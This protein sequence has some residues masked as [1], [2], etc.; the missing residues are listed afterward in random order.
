MRSVRIPFGDQ[1]VEKGNADVNC[2]VV[3]GIK[4]EDRCFHPN[5]SAQANFET[6]AAEMFDETRQIAGTVQRKP[7]DGPPGFSRHGSERAPFVSDQTGVNIWFLCVP[8]QR[9][10]E[11]KDRK[12]NTRPPNAWSAGRARK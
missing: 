11:K 3:R 9:S 10:A 6:G 8:S 12:E 1:S 5:C 2:G 4:I 7:F